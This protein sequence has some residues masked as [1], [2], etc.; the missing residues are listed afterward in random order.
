[1]QSSRIR[2]VALSRRSETDTAGGGHNKGVDVA[3]PTMSDDEMRAIARSLYPVG[4]LSQRNL[5][6]VAMSDSERARIV[7]EEVASDPALQSSGLAA[8]VRSALIRIGIAGAANLPPRLAAALQNLEHSL[9]AEIAA[10]QRGADERAR[11]HEQ[12]L[13]E[14]QT[15]ALGD[16]QAELDTSH[17]RVSELEA[18]VQTMDERCTASAA[19]VEHLESALAKAEADLRR[20]IDESAAERQSLTGEAKTARATADAA[21]DALMAATI[22]LEREQALHAGTSRNL[23]DAQRQCSQALAKVEELSAARARAEQ[24]LDHART[25]VE[26]L[27]ARLDAAITA[28]STVRRRPRK[29]AP[30]EG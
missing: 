24:E 30:S 2:S 13:V 28:R 23:A 16:V 4:L 20:H 25:E 9:A 1:M 6:A 8:P 15:A 27:R 7:S 18:V 5:R 14:Q 21:R 10:V 19:E 12:A 22:S 3:K 26:V 11:T 17:R 29:G